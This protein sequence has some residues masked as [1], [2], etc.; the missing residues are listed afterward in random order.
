MARQLS[1]IVALLAFAGATIAMPSAKGQLIGREK[2]CADDLE[3]AK[4]VRHYGPYT[5]PPESAGGKSCPAS[6][7]GDGETGCT[8]KLQIALQAATLLD[9]PLKVSLDWLTFSADSSVYT[10]TVGV[11]HTVGGDISAALSIK[12]I[13]TIGGGVSGSQT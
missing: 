2:P 9:I 3:Y 6:S 11:D 5:L 10:H 1:T 13:F 8:R 12:K 7:E 4:G